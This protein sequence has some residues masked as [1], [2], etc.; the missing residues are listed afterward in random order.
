MCRS[1]TPA[2]DLPP[3]SNKVRPAGLPLSRTLSSPVDFE[4]PESLWVDNRGRENGSLG[5]W[6]QTR[7]CL[8]VRALWAGL[9]LS[10]SPSASSSALSPQGALTLVALWLVAPAP[11]NPGSTRAPLTFVHLTCACLQR[12]H[13]HTELSGRATAGLQ[14][15]L[16]LLRQGRPSLVRCKCP[17]SN[18]P[19]AGLSGVVAAGS[20]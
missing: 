12:P 14:S 11:R 7:Y 15:P 5:S 9:F 6:S 20:M 17:G 16:R 18:K 13:S 1:H 10:P 8:Q 19:R 3:G 2:S 4:A